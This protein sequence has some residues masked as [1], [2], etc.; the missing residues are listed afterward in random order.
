MTG[1]LDLC[2]WHGWRATTSV[3]YRFVIDIGGNDSKLF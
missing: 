2:G 1:G 3:R